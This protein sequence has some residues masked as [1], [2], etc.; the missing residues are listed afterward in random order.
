[1]SSF[2]MANCSSFGTA[3]DFSRNINETFLVGWFGYDAIKEFIWAEELVPTKLPNAIRCKF[4]ASL[5]GLNLNDYAFMLE[6]CTKIAPRLLEVTHQPKSSSEYE[7]LSPP[8]STCLVCTESVGLVCHNE[9]SE[10]KYVSL[11]TMSQK[12]KVCLRCPR[13]RTNYNFSMCGKK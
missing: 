3:N 9:A 4:C 6:T 2:G 5:A 1:M 10:V 13:C 11:E 12:K 7:I 8:V